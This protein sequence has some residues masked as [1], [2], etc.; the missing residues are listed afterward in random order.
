MGARI[1]RSGDKQKKLI[2]VNVSIIQNVI[3]TKKKYFL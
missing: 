1:I 3:K 2:Y